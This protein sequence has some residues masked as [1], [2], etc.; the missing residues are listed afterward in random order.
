MA[1]N[2]TETAYIPVEADAY[3]VIELFGAPALFAN[4]R[5]TA[6]D[7]PQGLY[8]YYLRESDDGERFGTI[9]PKVAVNLSGTVIT[10]KPLDFGENGYIPLTDDASL[11]FTGEKVTFGEYM[12]G[13]FEMKE[14]QT[15]EME[16]MRL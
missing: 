7:I 16:D 9:E 14:E 10:A 8:C 3:E 15:N 2:R 5:L 6:K 13:E 11:N 4:E 1:L 12:R